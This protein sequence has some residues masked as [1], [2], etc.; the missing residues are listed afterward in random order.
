MGTTREMDELYEMKRG[1]EE[2]MRRGREKDIQ[3]FS[4]IDQ[5]EYP[6][7]KSS[8]PAIQLQYM[9]PGISTVRQ[10]SIYQLLFLSLVLQ[11]RVKGM[12]GVGHTANPT[13]SLIMGYETTGAKT[14]HSTTCS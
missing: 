6:T 12:R 7:D 5:S 11:Q 1:R 13:N 14:A 8:Y 10:Y 4:V 3:R 9:H 2:D